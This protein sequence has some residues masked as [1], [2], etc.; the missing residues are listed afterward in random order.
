MTPVVPL[1]VG[2]GRTPS[3]QWEP[4]KGCCCWGEQSVLIPA[5]CQP[6]LH[7]NAPPKSIRSAEGMRGRELRHLLVAAQAL[8]PSPLLCSRSGG[9]AQAPSP[10]VAPLPISKP[11]PGCSA[12]GV[13]PPSFPFRPEMFLILLR[14]TRCSKAPGVPALTVTTASPWSI[15]RLCA[16]CGS[17]E[18]RAS[19]PDLGSAWGTQAVRC[20]IGKGTPRHALQSSERCRL[21]E[22][23]AHPR[24]GADICW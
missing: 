4:Q 2:E 1:S 6:A 9:T 18:F 23:D 10:P 17:C 8:L 7:L 16:A 12:H 5:P 24:A 15:T 14:T 19:A 21:C 20:P 22:L 3:P 11:S 13:Y